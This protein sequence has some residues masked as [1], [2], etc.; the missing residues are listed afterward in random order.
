[1]NSEK[2]SVSQQQK[3]LQ[4][5]T[6]ILQFPKNV[7]V[8]F[9]RGDIDVRHSRTKTLLFLAVCPMYHVFCLLLSAPDL[10]RYRYGRALRP[11]FAHFLIQESV[12][13]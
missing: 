6:Y 11:I 3:N 5:V 10:L 2:D 12:K 9:E 4:T 7:G 8:S 13:K 1:M